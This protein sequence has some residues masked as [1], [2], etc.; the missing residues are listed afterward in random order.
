MAFAG[1]QGSGCGKGG[2]ERF[3]VCLGGAGDGPVVDKGG[4][5]GLAAAGVDVVVGEA[6]EV[7]PF[8]DLEADAC[9]C[10]APVLGEV[11]GTARS[12]DDD[13]GE[14]VQGLGEL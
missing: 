1:Y 5:P 11:F 3:G 13:V 14:F 9:R 12:E 8:D 7:E 4:G 2:P 10:G 6:V